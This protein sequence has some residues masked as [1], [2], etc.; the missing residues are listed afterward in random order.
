[1]SDKGW[2]AIPCM[3]LAVFA[4]VV[5]I[6][7]VFNEGVDKMKQEAVIN[8]HAEWMSDQSGKA[9]FKWKECK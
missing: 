9:V 8:G 4:C 3:L 7:T 6:T 5:L 2:L 1:M